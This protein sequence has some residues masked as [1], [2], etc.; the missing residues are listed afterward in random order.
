MN[1]LML[2]Y[3]LPLS[4]SLTMAGTNG[5]GL[6]SLGTIPR[7]VLPIVASTGFLAL[8]AGIIIQR[9]NRNRI[10]N[11]AQ[12]A[13]STNVKST[14]EASPDSVI[15]INEHGNILHFNTRT[16]RQFGHNLEDAIGRSMLDL[17]FAEERIEPST[18]P[19]R[20]YFSADRGISP[21][22]H[23]IQLIGRKKTGQLIPVTISI[24]CCEAETSKGFVV[25]VRDI[26]KQLAV[27][28]ELMQARDHAL[29]GERTKS[30]FIAVMSHE[31]RTPLN[32]LLG[33]LD[34]LSRTSLTTKQV[35]LLSIAQRSGQ[36]LLE[37][38]NDVLDISKIEAGKSSGEQRIFNPLD[39]INEVYEGQL[40]VAH[41]R[42]N[43][44]S[45]GEMIG[46]LGTVVGDPSGVRQILLNLVSNANKFTTGGA[47]HIEAEKL[48]DSSGT[49]EFRIADTGIG[50]ASES[51]Q[52]IFADFVTLDP[53]FDRQAEGTGLGLSI[54]KR[55]T[56]AMGG[57]IGVESEQGEGSLFWFR[58]PFGCQIE[59]Y[60]IV[61]QET[62][63]LPATE[64]NTKITPLKILVVEDNETNRFV[65]REMLE[66]DGHNVTEAIDG[67]AGV[68]AALKGFFDAILM[69][70]S[71]PKLDGISATKQIRKSSRNSPQ[72]PI[73]ALTA[74][75][76]PADIERFQ[77]AGMS[78][79]L[80]KPITQ[81]QLRYILAKSVERK[82]LD[83]IELSQT[84]DQSPQEKLINQEILF[85]LI[86]IIGLTRTS[87][88]L[89]RY[90]KEVKSA[91]SELQSIKQPDQIHTAI[92][93][94][95][96]LAGSSSTF[97]AHLL[98]E[99]FCRLE[100]KGRAKEYDGFIRILP[101]LSKI[102][103]ETELALNDSL[104]NRPH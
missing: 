7:L 35:Q 48:A 56:E 38:V 65:V 41:A 93:K 85:Q 59:E 15:L 31:M 83:N 57:E 21:P 49:I 25:Y 32:G 3:V 51:L 61:R 30:R 66:G 53:K 76:L 50:I 96:H 27:E 23:S 18:I 68:T 11:S 64:Q 77:A 82:S 40:S 12:F 101:N 92:P 90:L 22:E 80:T 95:H 4:M 46:D 34:L 47:I 36:L 14:M 58:V 62:P 5:V 24:G 73:I 33:T 44:L 70:I 74:H 71:M 6:V 81:K 88:L 55:L 100:E 72:T 1:F 99:T 79:Y 104:L 103:E 102:L 10:E 94:I 60:D 78:C 69:D 9:H 20:D 17:L 26:G 8:A 43:K 87:N 86:E 84:E 39:V 2:T 28:T 54:A 67:E 19:L 16:E 98:K 63:P 75:A 91:I 13:T 89:K 52:T 97:G 37:H 45:I 29:A 42:K